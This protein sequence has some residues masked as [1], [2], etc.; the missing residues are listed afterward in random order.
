MTENE[1]TKTEGIVP[2]P[3]FLASR[4]IALQR[5]AVE[6]ELCVVLNKP[7]NFNGARDFLLATLEEI[8]NH[9]NKGNRHGESDNQGQ[10][11]IIIPQ[12]GVSAS[13]NTT[14]QPRN[15]AG[16]SGG[17]NEGQDANHQVS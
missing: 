6:L 2:Q 17:T 4:F 8:I 12:E 1:E 9:L 3:N 14:E 16:S 15:E 11:D 13:S 7:T 5:A 10:E